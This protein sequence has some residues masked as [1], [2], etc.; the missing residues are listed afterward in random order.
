M[1]FGCSRPPHH[2]SM[3]LASGAWG[4]CMDAVVPA[5]QRDVAVAVAMLHDESGCAACAWPFRVELGSQAASPLGP[6]WVF[7][8]EVLAAGQAAGAPAFAP[9][10]PA[11]WRAHCTVAQRSHPPFAHV[12]AHQVMLAALLSSL[13]ISKQIHPHAPLPPPPAPPRPLAHP[14]SARCRFRLP[15]ILP[16]CACGPWCCGCFAC[17]GCHVFWCE[18]FM[19]P[20]GG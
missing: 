6:L 16:V 15:P 13:A 7:R 14:F 5:P 12:S 18:P 10:L 4:V 8:P 2:C 1:L 3:S 11:A 9:M 19:E 20:S 17:F